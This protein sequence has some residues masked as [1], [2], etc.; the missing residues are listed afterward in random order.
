M[1]VISAL[2]ATRSFEKTLPMVSYRFVIFLAI[3]F[4]YI[5]AIFLGAGT[6][7]AIG[8]MGDNPGFFASIGAFVGLCLFGFVH[9]CLRGSVLFST[10]AGHTA[11]LVKVFSEQQFPSGAVQIGQGK[12]SVKERF[13]NAAA[14]LAI[15]QSIKQVLTSLLLEHTSLGE[16][17]TKIANER[18]ARMARWLCGL[19]ITYTDELIIGFVL[20]QTT[21]AP[22]VAA[23]TALIYYAQNFKQL[24]KPACILFASMYAGLIAVFFLVRLPV[25]WVV[26]LIPFSVGIWSFVATLVLAWS[27]KATLFEPI[28][29][30]VLL[31][32]FL[33]KTQEQTPDPEWQTKLCKI[34]D[35]FKELTA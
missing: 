17:I 31:S 20:R 26:E 12:G 5:V 1:D 24:F 3:G 35:Q 13:D 34:S 32:D 14:L 25:E 21:E 8:S 4:G 30:A 16:K 19:P 2:Q 18:I 23:K 10:R 29:I 9:Y 27:I 11:L 6:G 7:F 33:V 15:D 28:A 22:A